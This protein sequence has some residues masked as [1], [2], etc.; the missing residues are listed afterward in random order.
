MPRIRKG[1]ETVAAV[2]AP[3][4]TDV[5]DVTKITSSSA[6]SKEHGG[7]H[8]GNSSDPL[9]VNREHLDNPSDEVAYAEYRED[10]A[11][12]MEDDEDVEEDDGP[13][14]VMEEVE[15]E[16][17]AP[18]YT[19][20]SAGP[21]AAEL[22]DRYRNN[23]SLIPD[24]QFQPPAL[25]GQEHPVFGKRL[26]AAEFV[27]KYPDGSPEWH[28]ARS[29]GIG[30]SDAACV[31]DVGFKSAHLLWLEKHGYVEP[32]DLAANPR[33]AEILKTGHLRE[34]EIGER[35]RERHPQWSVHEGGSWR[36]ADAP[37]MLSNP[38]RL[39]LNEETGEVSILECKTS[40]TGTGYE[41]GKCPTKYVVQL[42]HQLW[43][44]GLE[45]GYL[46]V[47]IGNS[48]Y[49][50]YYVPADPAGKIIRLF[51]R[52][53]RNEIVTECRFGD[54]PTME[55]GQYNFMMA[56]EPPPMS[57][58]KDIYEHIRQKNP[59]LERST[60]VDIP[61]E[62]ATALAEGKAL[63]EQG[64]D[65]VQWAKNHM[66][67]IMGTKHFAMYNGEKIASRVAVGKNP[68]YLKLA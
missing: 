42:R 28:K 18:G 67:A 13:P 41:E 1:A 48:D 29:A 37:W 64:S 7:W 61:V 27:G 35:F 30:S 20:P 36:K 19:P 63:E 26:G 60:Q 6:E 45:Y 59:T 11:P 58:H 23:N 46:G 39:L 4:T 9:L 47:V 53:N 50:E 62:I 31:L 33:M 32:E 17:Q 22:L 43:V 66:M 24:H 21:P 25:T 40:E 10:D 49:R 34:P 57:G 52:D 38:D 16:P 15:P 65:M 3:A 54:G 55:I 14:A 68:P 5:E 12:P 56:T 2:P 44:M 8:E 51:A